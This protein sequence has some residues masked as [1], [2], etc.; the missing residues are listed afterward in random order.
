[1]QGRIPATGLHYPNAV[2]RLFPR[3]LSENVLLIGRKADLG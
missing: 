1:L 3:A 2:S